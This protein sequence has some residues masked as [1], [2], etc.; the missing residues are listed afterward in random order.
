[1]KK[2]KIKGYLIILI[3]VLIIEFIIW[4]GN[5]L[6]KGDWSLVL[7]EE[8]SN[9]GFLIGSNL[10]IVIYI[11]WVLFDITKKKK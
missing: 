8:F 4:Y 9:I 5:Y 10:P 2:N 3:P 7:Q 1:M 6:E 11:I